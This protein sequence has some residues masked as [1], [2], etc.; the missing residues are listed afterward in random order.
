MAGTTIQ[1]LAEPIAIIGRSC[2]L[3]GAPSPD[4]YWDLL[5]D[6]RSGVR[7]LPASRLRPGG[8]GGFLDGIDEFDPEFFGISVREAAPWIRSSA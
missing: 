6:G 3:P 5:R 2:R 4:A 1:P 8:R 7:D